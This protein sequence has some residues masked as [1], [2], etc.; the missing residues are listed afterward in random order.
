MNESYPIRCSLCGWLVREQT[1]WCDP[2]CLEFHS[3]ARAHSLRHD[4]SATS[5]APGTAGGRSPAVTG[6]SPQ[7]A[8]RIAP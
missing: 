1:D 5:V 4:A 7:L 8:M 6:N 3:V 2:D